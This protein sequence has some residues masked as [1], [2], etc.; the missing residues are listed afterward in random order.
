[1]TPPNE[2]REPN[3]PPEPDAERDVPVDP[4]DE[5]LSAALDGFE[6]T[7]ELDAST[8]DRGRDL[9]AA[10]DRLAVPPPPL[11]DLTRRRLLRTALDAST[12][13]SRPS[14]ERTW[15][16]LRVGAVAAAVIV[17][18]GLAGWGLSSL[19]LG[20]NSKESGS[21]AD[22]AETSGPRGPVNLHDVSNPEVLKRRVESELRAT[23]APGASGTATTTAAPNLEQTTTARRPPSAADCVASVPVP[24]GD[25]PQLLGTATFH[26]APAFV[27]IARERTRTLVFVLA[28][29]DCKLLTSQFLKQ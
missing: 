19:D 1:M 6:P 26:D 2:P 20:S 28:Q 3:E 14:G 22:S 18:L 25:T 21:K 5:R 12:T 15:R 24:A 9:A 8:R 10:R 11:D 4:L 27:V 7:S 29:T 13:S 16:W 17:V 23:S